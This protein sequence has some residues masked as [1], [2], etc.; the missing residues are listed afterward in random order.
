MSA[1]RSLLAQV[2]EAQSLNSTLSG[3][4]LRRAG[5]KVARLAV[6]RG[7]TL[8]PADASGERLIGA[9]LLA[10]DRVRSADASQRLDGQS[11]LLV[12][13]Y[14][15]GTASLEASAGVAN[16]LG[17]ARVQIAALGAMRSDIAGTEAY[18]SIEASP[19]HLV[20]L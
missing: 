5:R 15:A 19:A 3:D 14:Q 2:C 8:V 11:V 9:A 13:G 12:A 6:E 10:D 4:E 20:A 7:L 16:R 18:S 17:A 1:T